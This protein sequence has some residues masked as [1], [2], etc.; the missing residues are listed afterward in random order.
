M[1]MEE[2]TQGTLDQIDSIIADDSMTANEEVIANNEA[3]SM[4][5][6]EETDEIADASMQLNLIPL[7]PSN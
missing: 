5:A 1:E 3:D 7:S 4:I 6:N 2:F